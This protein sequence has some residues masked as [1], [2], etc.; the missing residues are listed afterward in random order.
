MNDAR[1]ASN[2]DGSAAPDLARYSR[3]VLYANIGEMGQRRLLESRV[4]LIGCGALGTVL[5]ETLVRAGVKTY[6]QIP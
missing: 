4:C 2:A 1:S 5:A 3:Q 6:G